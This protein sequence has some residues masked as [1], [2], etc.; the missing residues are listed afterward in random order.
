MDDTLA[1]TNR[2]ACANCIVYTIVVLFLQEAISG[3]AVKQ[4]CCGGTIDVVAAID[5]GGGDFKDRSLFTREACQMRRY[6]VA[7]I[8]KY[9]GTPKAQELYEKFL[10][11]MDLPWVS[12]SPSECSNLGTTY[13]PDLCGA[14]PKFACRVETETV[15]AC[16]SHTL[17]KDRPASE[18]EERFHFLAHRRIQKSQCQVFSDAPVEKASW[19]SLLPE[20]TAAYFVASKDCTGKILEKVH[21]GVLAFETCE[22]SWK[23]NQPTAFWACA[24]NWKLNRVT[25]GKRKYRCGCAN[26]KTEQE[27]KESLQAALRVGH[28]YKPESCYRV[29]DDYQFNM[30][31]KVDLATLKTAKDL[32]VI[33]TRTKV[34]IRELKKAIQSEKKMPKKKQPT[35]VK[36][37]VTSKGGSKRASVPSGSAYQYRVERR[38]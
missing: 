26:P 8:A 13:S 25:T 21:L 17:F 22:Q 34:D 6:M 29:S 19:Q 3:A 10:S 28:L 18:F 15:C 36:M 14:L 2:L 16:M 31:T 33:D 7:Y 24:E 20:K 35:T 32:N 1:C 12:Y 27:A 9:K 30:D 5:P 38:Y 23:T 4:A 11:E 37:R